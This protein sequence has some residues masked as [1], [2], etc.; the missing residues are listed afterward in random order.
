MK[1]L[2]VFAFLL[3]TASNVWAQKSEPL[4]LEIPAPAGSDPFNYVAA[5]K[6]GICIFFPTVSGSGKDSISW[7]FTM[8]DDQLKEKW[9]RMVPLHKDVTYL[10]SISSKEAIYLLFHDTKQNKEG[11]IFVFMIIPRLQVITEHRGSIPDKAEVVDFELS[12]NVA[13]IGYNSRKSQ[14][15]IIGFSLVTGEKSKYDITTEK[16]ALL[17]DI[18]IDTTRQDIFATYKIQYSSTRNH[19]YVNQYNLPGALVKTFD[20]TEQV[21]KKNF[22]SAQFIPRGEG[23]GVVAGTYGFN[24]TSTRRQYDYYD[25]YYN[26]YYY[27]YYSPYYSRQ[28][29]YD[30]NEDKTPVSDGYFTATV[31]NGIADKIKY[32]NFSGFSNAFKYITDP[33]ALRAKARPLKKKEKTSESEST[34]TDILNDKTLNLR[35]ITHELLVNNGQII[36][37]SEAYSPEYHTNTQMSYDFYGRAFPTSYQVFDGFRYSHA[38]VAG[39]DSIGNM[40]WNNGMEMRDIITKYLNRKLNCLFENDETVLYY[41]ANNKVAFKT[42]KGSTIVENTSYTTLVPKRTNDQPYD[43]Y[44]G[45]IE[46]WYDDYFIATGYQTIRNNYLENNKRNVF[47]ISKMAFR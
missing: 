38:F 43:E 47:Y 34:N 14:P 33:N 4:R 26:S 22:N 11:N 16:D 29:D 15:G 28:P 35:L 27:N 13:Y 39:F 23:N 30:A 1:K 32:Y 21:E 20:F 6:N 8:T 19:L 3:F 40:L 25:N 18:S 5:G 36:I 24:V 45:T 2:F 12:D 46:H 10:K 44:L 17:L 7:S 41:N 37:S 9:H 31:S 42:I